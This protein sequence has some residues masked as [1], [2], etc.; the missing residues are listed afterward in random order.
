VPW[1]WYVRTGER[2]WAPGTEG[3]DRTFLM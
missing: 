2:R 3:P 1:S